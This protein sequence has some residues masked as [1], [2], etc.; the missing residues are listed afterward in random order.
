MSIFRFFLF[1]RPNG[2]YYITYLDESRI[3]WKSTGHSRKEAMRSLTEFE[4]LLK[5]K[6]NLLP[7]RNSQIPS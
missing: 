6:K 3:W 7:F 4:P 2:I 1:K 5:S